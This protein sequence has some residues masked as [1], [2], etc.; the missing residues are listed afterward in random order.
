MGWARTGARSTA[1]RLRDTLTGVV[2]ISAFLLTAPTAL[3]ATAPTTTSLCPLAANRG[4]H[5]TYTENGLR[6]LRTSVTD[7]AQLLEFDVRI[8][9]DQQPILM[10]SSRV[11]RTTNG[12]GSVARLTAARVRALRLDDREH[13]P[14]LAQALQVAA[15]NHVGA[16][17]ELKAMGTATSYRRVAAQ[18]RASGVSDLVVASS[19]TTILSRIHAYHS[20]L[21]R[22][23]VTSQAVGTA[24]AKA[25]GALEVAQSAA[26]DTWVRSMRIAGVRL[27]VYS[28][29]TAAAWDRLSGDVDGVITNDPKAYAAYRRTA[30]GCQPPWSVAQTTAAGGALMC[31]VAAHR[32]DHAIATEDGLNAMRAAAADGADYLELDVRATK[33][34]YPVLLHDPTVDRTTD[35][36]GAVDALTLA[37]LRE[38]R[39]DDGEQVP[40]LAEALQVAADNDV[41]AFVELK[42]TGT[43]TYYQRFADAIRASGVRNMVVDSFEPG[44]LDTLRPYLP[45]VRF[46]LLTTS[47]VTPA[48]AAGYGSVQISVA[49]VTDE[50]LATMKAAHV[51]VYL[52]TV[53]TAADWS[54]YSG[55]VAGLITNDAPGY[56]L[57]RSTAPACQ[58]PAPATT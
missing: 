42:A 4:D 20:T 48:Q 11:D 25:Y 26:T 29:D 47:R 12:T 5:A 44:Y 35:G 24:R 32:G 31:P 9:K 37:Q 28:A 45:R 51:V 56:V 50:W 2:A 49:A 6:S 27:F 17:V 16:L 22:A 41:G 7:G 18:L 33:D 53:D 38:L 46:S 54:S 36:T 13:V 19:S 8:T 23:L 43:P 10:N 3:A 1:R 30:A 34:L 40:T 52:W 21:Q 14:T 58:P 15:D 57:Y 55:R 39:L